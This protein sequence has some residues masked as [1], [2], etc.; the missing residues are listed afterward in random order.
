M[1]ERLAQQ[2]ALLSTIDP[3]GLAT[4]TDV[5]GD[6]IDASLYDSLL[7]IVSLGTITSSGEV[8]LTIYKG[9]GSTAT[10]ITTSVESVDFGFADDNKQ[11]IVDIDV[12]KEGKRYYMP[13]LTS[14]AET[15]A[16]ACFASVVVLGSSARFH[17]GIDNDLGSVTVTM[18]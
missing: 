1:G 16:T 11:H 10:G 13:T 3:R 14:N 2:V 15:T 4:G 17:S 8:T 6:I 9:D 7:F 18:A 12:S 5:D